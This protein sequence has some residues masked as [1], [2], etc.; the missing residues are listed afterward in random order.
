LELAEESFV[1]G[2]MLGYLQRTVDA[3]ETTLSTQADKPILDNDVASGLYNNLPTQF[4]QALI[5]AFDKPDY[6]PDRTH[7]LREAERLK[8]AA[9]K[10]GLPLND[11][12]EQTRILYGER[13]SKND[14][15]PLRVIRNALFSNRGPTQG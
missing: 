12:F 15:N 13:Y 9:E 8:E 6:D 3:L 4:E 11:V 1:Q 2:D 14:W 7:L 5:Q 10:L